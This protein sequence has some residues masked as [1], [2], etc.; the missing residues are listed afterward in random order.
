MAFVIDAWKRSFEG[1][2]AVRG[3]DR[4][5]YRREMTLAIRRLC[6]RAQIRIATA[7]DDDDHLLG[8]AAFTT[9]DDGAELHYV[10]VK[11]DFRKMGIARKLL[12]D[13]K[14]NAVTF[15]STTARLPKGWAYKPR[16]TIDGRS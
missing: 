16:F 1:A 12:A 3:C 4:E 15:L 7:P 9:T 13:L 10:Y 11:Q 2:P 14:V 8:F 6:D 5:H